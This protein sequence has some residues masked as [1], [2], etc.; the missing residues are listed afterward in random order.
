M[1]AVHVMLVLSKEVNAVNFSVD[2]YMPCVIC[3]G[4]CPLLISTPL[5]FQTMLSLLA[6]Q[7]NSATSL[8]ETLTDCGECKSSTN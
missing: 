7:L 8:S 6:V 5:V 2:K 1:T 4:I 3:I